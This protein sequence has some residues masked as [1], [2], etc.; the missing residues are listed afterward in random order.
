MTNVVEPATEKKH[1]ISS[2]LNYA[3]GEE[4]ITRIA[5]LL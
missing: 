4:A 2:T 1:T 3:L 5:K